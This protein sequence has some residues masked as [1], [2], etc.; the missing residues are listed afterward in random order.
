MGAESKSLRALSNS[1]RS[2]REQ[3][4]AA[5]SGHLGKRTKLSPF[6]V[7]AKC[8]KISR[9]VQAVTG[10]NSLISAMAVSTTPR[11]LFF[12]ALLFG[13]SRKDSDMSKAS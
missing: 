7:S 8:S 11:A 3:S 12:R 4:W 10:E 6:R 13:L 1:M 2:L 9:R 5:F